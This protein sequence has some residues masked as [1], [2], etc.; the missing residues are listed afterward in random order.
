MTCRCEKIL[1]LHGNE[2][3]EY[4]RS[5]LVEVRAMDDDWTTEF[6]CPVTGHRWLLDY[7]HSG[8]HGGGPPRLRRMDTIEPSEA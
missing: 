3:L 5:H 7:P 4:S 2:A 1:E 8:Q 6:S